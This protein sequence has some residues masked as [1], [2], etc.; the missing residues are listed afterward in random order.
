MRVYPKELRSR[1]L[2]WAESPHGDGVFPPSEEGRLP[3][4]CPI[5]PC[6][7]PTTAVR[8]V[9]L[10]LK[11]D[12]G[13]VAWGVDA[14]AV[15][16]ERRWRWHRRMPRVP[17]KVQ[18][19]AVA[20]LFVAA[21]ATLWTTW[22]SVVEREGRRTT[23]RTVLDRAGIALAARGAALLGNA[24]RWPTALSGAIGMSWITGWREPDAALRPLGGV[25]GGYYLRDFGKF[26]GTSH[27][28]D[29]A[30]P[31]PKPR[32]TS[33]RAGRGTALGPPPARPT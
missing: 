27:P 31:K 8:A 23:T 25:E 13:P 14:M 12:F 29:R 4:Q 3:G 6:P 10:W 24:A 1:P 19:G 11:L 17:L 22:A 7:V 2:G 9:L 21:L 26:L 20:A 33:R 5:P 32:S 18:A 16:Q 30:P 28:P 15:G